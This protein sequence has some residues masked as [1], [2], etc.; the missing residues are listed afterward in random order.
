MEDIMESVQEYSDDR[1]SGGGDS[2]GSQ[3][4]DRAERRERMKAQIRRD[5]I[6]AR[7]AN[8]AI[9][10]QLE[11][12]GVAP[13][14]GAS[15][16]ALQRPDPWSRWDPWRGHGRRIAR[17]RRAPFQGRTGIHRT[18]WAKLCRTWDTQA[19]LGPT[20][21]L[22]NHGPRAPATFYCHTRKGRLLDPQDPSGE[23]PGPIKRRHQRRRP[24]GRLRYEGRKG[25][26]DQQR[27]GPKA[28][29]W[30]DPRRPG[31]A[32]RPDGPDGS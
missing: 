9:R 17:P 27:P 1:S 16:S 22:P 6:E 20:T 28:H 12:Q 21:G 5:D 29:R 13:C 19:G 31:R 10:R 18:Y 15:L 8:A 2:D 23:T 30:A 11:T 26:K 3:R 4:Q 7:A 25:R 32:Q 14:K 24:R